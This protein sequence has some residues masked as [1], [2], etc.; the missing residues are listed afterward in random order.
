LDVGG[1]E[2]GATP[3][4]ASRILVAI[5]RDEVVSIARRSTDDAARRGAIKGNSAALDD[6]PRRE[7][8]A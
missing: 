6:D 5:G 7:A 4:A 2:S 3:E 8:Q 1:H